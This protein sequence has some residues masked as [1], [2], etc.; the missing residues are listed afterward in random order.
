MIYAVAVEAGTG[1]VLVV[2][3]VAFVVWAIARRNAH[4]DQTV[5]QLKQVEGSIIGLTLSTEG[6]GASYSEM[7]CQLVSV[8]RNDLIVE[9]VGPLPTAVLTSTPDPEGRMSVPMRLISTIDTPRGQ[10]VLRDYWTID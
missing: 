2:T 5:E 8:E 6:R 3:V 1:V 9:P 10:I 4:T 7:S